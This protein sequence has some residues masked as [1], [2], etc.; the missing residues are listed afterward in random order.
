MTT[1][2][3]RRLR[4][5][6]LAG[7]TA[8]LLIAINQLYDMSL[9]D[10]AFMNGWVLFAGMVFLSLFNARKKLNVVPLLPIAV[11]LQ[12]HIYVGV[13]CGLLFLLHTDFAWPNG[14]FETVLWLMFVIV[15]V[16][17]LIGVALSRALPPRL[18]ARGP[19]VLFERIPMLRAQL[20]RQVQELAMRSVEETRA[21]IIADFYVAELAPFLQK[22]RNLFSHLIGSH[23]PERRLHVAIQEL[24]RYLDERGRQILVEIDQLVTAKASLDYQYA[25]Q[26]TLKGWLFFHLPLNYG[27][28]LFSLAHIVI[29]YAFASGAP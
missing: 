26:L 23:R 6:A 4:N 12:I 16:S 24:E 3:Q 28:M 7:M 21:S 14:A 10:T 5:L 2:T 18:D 11:W 9:R 27:L 19:R 25:M 20:A 15:V 29:V 13:L 8:G 22:P 1:F 17:G